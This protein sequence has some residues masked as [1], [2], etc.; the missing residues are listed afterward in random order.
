MLFGDDGTQCFARQTSCDY[1]KEKST[2]FLK[3][4]L[5]QPQQGTSEPEPKI[6]EVIPFMA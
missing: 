6:V 5:R 2:P 1:E 4:H 3:K